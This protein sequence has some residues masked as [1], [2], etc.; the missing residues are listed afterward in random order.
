MCV[1]VSLQRYVE[2]LFVIVDKCFQDLSTKG[3]HMG[4]FLLMEV[5]RVDRA[6][7][8]GGLKHVVRVMGPG[9]QAASLVLMVNL[10]VCLWLYHRNS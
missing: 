4:E 1:S 9:E 3:I 8:F 5:H 7:L 6:L 10:C 2:I